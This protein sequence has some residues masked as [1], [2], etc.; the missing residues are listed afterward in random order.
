MEYFLG[1]VI[2]TVLMTVLLRM[3]RQESRQIRVKLTY[4]QSHIFNLA[5]YSWLTSSGYRDAPD[6][7]DTQATRH[8]DSRHMRVLFLNNRAYWIKNQQ[9]YVADVLDGVVDEQSTKT[10]DMMALDKVELDEMIFIIEKLNEGSNKY[11][12]GNSGN[13]KF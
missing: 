10:L 1:A 8:F 11:D 6:E 5:R 7:I 2:A 4:R 9:V 12:G 3:V 13:Q